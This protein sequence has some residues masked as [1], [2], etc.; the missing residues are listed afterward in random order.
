VKKLSTVTLLQ[1]PNRV[2]QDR[3]CMYGVFM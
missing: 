3:H 1:E 2:P